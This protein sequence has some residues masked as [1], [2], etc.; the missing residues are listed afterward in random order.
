[1]KLGITGT[2]HGWTPE[3][4]TTFIDKVSAFFAANHPVVEFHHGDCTGVDEQAAVELRDNWDV[5][6]HTHPPKNGSRRANLG[7][8]LY[9]P[10][11]YIQRNHDIVDAVDELV[12]I[13]DSHVEQRR[14]GTWATYR[15]AQ[16]VG[17]PI[18]LIYPDG[19][20]Q[21]ENYVK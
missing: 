11:E 15:Y 5:Q 12:V 21:L 10:K 4:K 20:I 6:L 13:P 19:T 7:G 3:Q 1:M 17:K 8:T 9:L 14:S 18:L 2:R 16:S